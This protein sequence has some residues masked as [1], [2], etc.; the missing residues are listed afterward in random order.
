MLGACAAR[1]HLKSGAVLYLCVDA[2]PYC[3]GCSSVD[4]E[5]YVGCEVS[6]GASHWHMMEPS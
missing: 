4:L 3:C 2:R 6:E 5:C 1:Q